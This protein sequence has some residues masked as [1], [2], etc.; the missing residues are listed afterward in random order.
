M[1]FRAA[2]RNLDPSLSVGMTNSKMTMLGSLQLLQPTTISEASKALAEYGENAKIYAGG[3]ELLL[4]LRQG[5]LQTELLVNIKK[6]ERFHRISI[7]ANGFRVGACVTHH[8]LETS[9][10]VREHAPSFA[11]AE[12]QVANVRVR[13]QGTL[14]GNLCFNDPHS[15]PGTVLL[16]HNA[17]VTLGSYKGER[18]IALNDFFLDMYTTALEPDEIL[19]EVQIPDLP[20]EMKSAYLR[21]HRYQRPTLG[22]AVAAKMD[23][24]TVEDLRLAV[25]CVS[26]RAQQLP[27]IEAKI[28]GTN[29]SGAK[30]IFAEQ[31]NYLRDVL[32][33]VDDLLGSAEYKIYMTGVLLGDA[34]EQAA[35]KNGNRK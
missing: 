33:P 26:S 35:G 27:E 14:G 34:L 1:S 30:R 31:K 20:T 25:G 32:R 4:L 13:N 7:E 11:Y 19:L 5:L 9:P 8:T 16:V 3:A 12:S 23:K 6:I 29:V 21:L 15:D 2:A 24:G 17:S 10:I 28:K 22:V 18:Q